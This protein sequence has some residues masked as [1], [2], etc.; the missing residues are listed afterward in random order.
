VPIRREERLVKVPTIKSVAGSDL[1]V[2]TDMQKNIFRET[3]Q[4]MK[5]E[6]TSMHDQW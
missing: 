1:A 6:S 5:K 2:V 3:E 4:E